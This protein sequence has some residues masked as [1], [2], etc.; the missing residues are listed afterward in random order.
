MGC[1]HRLFQEE[2][3]AATLS[4]EDLTRLL[5]NG[6]AGGRASA[7]E[8]GDEGEGAEGEQEEAEGAE[9]AEG[10]GREGGGGDEEP[11]G[12]TAAKPGD[13]EG[14]ERIV[15][16]QGAATSHGGKLHTMFRS[17][18]Q[19]EAAGGGGREGSER[20]EKRARASSGPGGGAGAESDA[21]GA[22]SSKR[23]RT[24]E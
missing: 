7:E 8:G 24:Q 4:E 17:P 18:F 1:P 2:N 22:P 19:A 13:R 20:Q 5:A 15:F 6:I 10:R 3:L 21:E 11:R 16:H 9:V 12:G 23:P 14:S